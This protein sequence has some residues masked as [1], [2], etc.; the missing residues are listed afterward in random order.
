MGMGS[1]GWDGFGA[2]QVWWRDDEEGREDG[3]D[4]HGALSVAL[5]AFIPGVLV[6][7]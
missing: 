6:G 7:E 1:E 2:T 5:V 3:G 4:V